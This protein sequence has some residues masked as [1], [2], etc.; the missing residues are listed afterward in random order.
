MVEMWSYFRT[1]TL[2]CG[3]SKPWSWWIGSVPVQMN[4][5]C[6]G[7]AVVIC[8]MDYFTGVGYSS[9]T[10]HFS[11]TVTLIILG[12][13][14][15]SGGLLRLYCTT[16]FPPIF[17]QLRKGPLWNCADLLQ[18]YG[19]CSSY[20]C[21]TVKL[22]LPAT[23]NCSGVCCEQGIVEWGL[24]VLQ[25]VGTIKSL[26]WRCVHMY[27]LYACVY[28]CLCVYVCRHVYICMCI[29][30]V[31]MKIIKKMVPTH[32]LYKTLRTRLFNLA[33]TGVSWV[34]ITRRVNLTLR[35]PTEHEQKTPLQRTSTSPS[36]LN[37]RQNRSQPLAYQTHSTGLGSQS[38]Y[39]SLTNVQDT[40]SVCKENAWPDQNIHRQ[41][42]YTVGI[43]QLA[44]NSR[45]EEA[46]TA[47]FFR[48]WPA[49]EAAATR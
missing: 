15:L 11:W 9:L 14:F 7:I 16:V 41:T 2:T 48:T 13:G 40:L 29:F 5:Y 45:K 8:V 32:R 23:A 3:V 19:L 44:N 38:D 12:L 17:L 21:R 37:T 43:L 36:L 1:S 33:R 24:L 35:L 47:T 49:Q 31:E 22:R 6:L 34:C 30:P 26:Y 27:I 20:Q 46:R 4:R 39:T 42:L 18:I 28:M 25:D 10:L